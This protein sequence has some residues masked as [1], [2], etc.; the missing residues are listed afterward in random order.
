MFHSE[1]VFLKLLETELLNLGLL[2]LLMMKISDLEMHLNNWTQQ[3]ANL[4]D[5]LGATDPSAYMT[6]AKVYQLGR[7]SEKSSQRT[8][9]G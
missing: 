8:A 6:N 5:N 4:D 1:V 7:G 9:S 3:I 2:Q